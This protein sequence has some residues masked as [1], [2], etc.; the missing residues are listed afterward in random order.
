MNIIESI[1]LIVAKQ[2]TILEN[3]NGEPFIENS[4][5][6]DEKN[7]YVF[8]NKY[9]KTIDEKNSLIRFYNILKTGLIEL[10]KPVIIYDSKNRRLNYPKIDNYFSENIIYKA[11]IFYCNFNNNIPIDDELKAICL[12]KPKEILKD[13]NIVDAISNLKSQGKNYNKNNFEDLL[14]LINKIKIKNN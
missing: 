13:L 2:A 11:F 8:L 14:N 4:C 7:I 12:D 9:D 6:Y 3:N 5:C 1:E 10:N